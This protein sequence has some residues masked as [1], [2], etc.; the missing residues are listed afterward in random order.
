MEEMYLCSVF[1]FLSKIFVIFLRPLFWVLVL[2]LWALLTKRPRRKKVL[3]IVSLCMAFLCSNR[4]VVNE[5]ALLWEPEIKEESSTLPRLAV[6]LG[7]FAEYDASRKRVQLTESAERLFEAFRLVKNGKVDTVLISGGTASINRELIPESI[8]ARKY[9][10]DLGVDSGK[11]LIDTASKNTWEN[12]KYTKQILESA[13]HRGPVLLITSAF[14]MPRA[15]KTF[16]KAGIEVVAHPVQFISDPGRGYIFSDYVMP[17][18]QA[19]SNFEV[20]I[21]EWVG[22]MVYRI[23][24]KA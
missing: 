9:L 24:G 10:M 5:L 8:Y 14:H 18:S 4:V 2:G 3:I 16:A 6:V 11:I 23:S 13:K 12:A 15:K 1:F 17:S 7:G 22:Y 21:K 19:L 20:L